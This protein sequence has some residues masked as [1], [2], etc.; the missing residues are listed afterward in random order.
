[1]SLQHTL[2]SSLAF[3]LAAT[4][5]LTAAQSASSRGTSH[6]ARRTAHG[7]LRT[8]HPS[9]SPPDPSAFDLQVKL[10]RA[11]F[12]PGEIDGRSGSNTTRAMNAF[13]TARHV[14]P[15]AASV[16]AALA[17]DSAPTVVPYTIAAADVA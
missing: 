15:D 5:P 13:A 2:R 12:S 8:Q 17:S 10:A 11:H 3:V 4:V 1:M 14:S 7:A 9:P 6:A 16:L